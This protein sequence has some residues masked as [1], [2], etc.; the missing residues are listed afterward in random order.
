MELWGLDT[1]AEWSK[2]TSL[3][4]FKTQS[5]PRFERLRHRFA[6]FCTLWRAKINRKGDV[7]KWWLDNFD[8][9]M[10]LESGPYQVENT[11]LQISNPRNLK[12]KRKYLFGHIGKAVLEAL[13]W[14]KFRKTSKNEDLS[15]EW[16]CCHLLEIRQG[17]RPRNITS[18]LLPSIKKQKN[19]LQFDKPRLG[20]IWN[21]EISPK[22][23]V[24]IWSNFANNLK[25][26]AKKMH[27]ENFFID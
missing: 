8:F 9:D 17:K 14:A 23:W 15:I 25:S 11:H 2:A 3:G 18:I 12:Y 13:C 5:R 21:P 19:I 22:V 10:I 4:L 6:H 16:L 27:F 1:E 20:E 26:S 7:W 24:W